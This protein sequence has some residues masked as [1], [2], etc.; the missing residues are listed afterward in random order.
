MMAG[1]NGETEK[2][3]LSAK[4]GAE[5]LEALRDGRSFFL[6]GEAVADHV[7]HPAF[8]NSV[9]VG[10][11]LYDFAAHPDNI[12]KM[13]FASPSSGRQVSRAWQ[14]PTNYE[15]LVE[16]RKA[17]SEISRITCGWVGR[18]PDHVASA[19]SGMVMSID[20]FERHGRARAA[21]LNDYFTWA[22]DNDVWC[23]YAIVPAQI[24][25][26]PPA[27]PGEPVNATIV[28]EDAEGITI[29]GSRQLATGLTMAQELLVAAVQPLKPG[30]EKVGFTA[31]VPLSAKGMKLISRRSYELGT[32]EFDAPLSSRFDENDAVVYFDEVK[33]PWERVF[34]HN[35]VE[36]ARAQWF[37]TP[38]MAYQNYPAQ[39][40]LSN[41]LT[42][43]LGLA[44]RMSQA[45]GTVRMPGTQEALGQ[46]AADVNQ[47]LSMVAAMEV[48][49]VYHGK[50]FIPNPGIQYS[51]QVLSQQLYP[52][53]INR[54]R[55]LAG[56]SVL[57]RP[58]S[59][60]D[61]TSVETSELIE[62]T[63]ASGVLSAVDRVKLFNLAWD[64]IG[65]EF[66]SRHTQYEM[67]YAGPTFSS[68][69]RNFSA[70][71]WDGAGATVDALLE[72]IAN[73]V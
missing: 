38:V 29:K 34:V 54:F 65:S 30:E 18:S 23:G 52:N 56:G 12:E 26:L 39:I 47:V 73:P 60:L 6:D 68:R 3:P 11:S 13:T 22:R 59:H 43:L 50:Y 16:R 36:I 71:D 41:K 9:R 27:K 31:M 72:T 51:S 10:A 55:E 45:N 70:F 44:Y 49:G 35:D 24:D 15:E 5:H 64:A 8:R 63:Q 37:D 42:F 33:I 61:L 25:R 40:R 2:T 7:D 57:A 4:T 21:A 32:S 28:D 17:I 20:L 62:R 67:F 53:F 14:L 58:S 48:N 46:M 66:G 1:P 19:L 69:M